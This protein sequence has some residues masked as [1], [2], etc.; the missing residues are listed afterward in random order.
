M[1]A[2]GL[3]DLLTPGDLTGGETVAGTGVITVDGKVG[4]IGG[5]QQKILAAERAG[6]IVFLIPQGNLAETEDLAGIR[7]VPVKRLSDALRFLR[8]LPK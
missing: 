1:W 6:A 8:D 7:L 2:L 4:P 5:V 3:Y